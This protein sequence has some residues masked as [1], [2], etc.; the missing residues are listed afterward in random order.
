MPDASEWALAEL[1]IDQAA[2]P[3]EAARRA[4]VQCRVRSALGELSD[5]DRN[6]LVLRHLEQLSVRDIA[7]VL[8]ISEGAVKLRHLRAVQRL[9]VVLG[10]DGPEGRP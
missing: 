9:R 3:S 8:G 6:V 2:G 7:G 1:L 4:E 10:A 5:S